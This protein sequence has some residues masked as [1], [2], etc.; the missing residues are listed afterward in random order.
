MR[1]HFSWSF[2]LEFRCDPSPA[3][4]ATATVAW[5]LSACWMSA[6]MSL[7]TA[8]HCGHTSL[9][10]VVAV[11]STGLAAA[12]PPRDDDAS[13]CALFTWAMSCETY[14]NFFWH[15]GHSSEL[16]VI[17]F[18]DAALTDAPAAYNNNNNIN[19]HVKPQ[20]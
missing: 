6:L 3:A 15:I 12:D 17:K 5:A 1:L 9:P 11:K 2:P 20:K 16:V 4:A 18:A 19:A 8:R 10:L 7:N 14:A 13:G